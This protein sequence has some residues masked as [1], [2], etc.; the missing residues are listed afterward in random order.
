[1]L[2]F[3][4]LLTKDASSTSDMGCLKLPVLRQEQSE[5]LTR[6]TSK[7]NMD[8]HPSSQI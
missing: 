8:P 5:V 2:M 4:I 3:K 6:L 1:M 7:L